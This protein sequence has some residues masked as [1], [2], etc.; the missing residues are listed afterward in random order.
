MPVGDGGAVYSMMRRDGHDVGGD[1]DPA[2]GAAGRRRSAAVE[3]LHLG[4]ERRRR[5]RAGDGARGRRCTRDR[6]TSSTAGRMAVIA[7]PQGAFFMVWEKRGPLRR[8]SRQ[9]AGRAV[10]ERARLT[11]PA[12]VG[13]SST[14]RS[15]AGTV[16]PMEGMPMAVLRRQERRAQQ[17][18]HHRACARRRRRT[19]SSTSRPRRSTPGSPTRRSSAA[20]KL[21]GPHDIGIAKFAVIADPQGATFALYAGKL[22]D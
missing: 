1:H 13:A 22:D 16:T 19:G 2:A 4:R 17:R 6:S 7:D 11:R 9:L 10:V 20:T 21:S 3:L 15:S 18:R 5:G 12:G 8:E 14:R